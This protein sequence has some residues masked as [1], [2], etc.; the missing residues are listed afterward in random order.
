[1]Q[2]GVV[3]GSGVGQGGHVLRPPP[4]ETD[5]GAEADDAVLRA[6]GSLLDAHVPPV[7]AHGRFPHRERHRADETVGGDGAIVARGGRVCLAGDHELN[8][9]LLGVLDR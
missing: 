7:G 2:S 5:P 3:R 4:A 8:R 6:G 1:M 9:V